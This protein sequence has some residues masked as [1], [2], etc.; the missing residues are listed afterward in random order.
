LGL[1]QTQYFKGLGNKQIMAANEINFIKLI[2][3]PLHEVLNEYLG[4][5]LGALLEHIRKNILE[6]EKLKQ[7]TQSEEVLIERDEAE[8]QDEDEDEDEDEEVDQK[9]AR[10]LEEEDELGL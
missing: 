3:K 2:V 1:S 5:E 8:E 9:Q 6:W 4:N 7:Q 10:E